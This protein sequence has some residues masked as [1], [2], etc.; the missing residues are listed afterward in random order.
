[1][2]ATSSSKIVAFADEAGW[3]GPVR[4]IQASLDHQ[5]SLIYYQF[6]SNMRRKSKWIQPLFARFCA[7]APPNAKL[8][9]TEAFKPGNEAWGAVA[10]QVRSELFELMKKSR[11]IV[12]YVARRAALSRKLYE[13]LR[14]IEKRR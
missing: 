11:I 14:K 5:I 10:F 7:A 6:L 8:H 9:I 1:M 4:E 13:N 12:I 2:S 3:R